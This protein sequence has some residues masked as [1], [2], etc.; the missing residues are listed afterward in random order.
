MTFDYSSIK[1]VVSYGP[2]RNYKDSLLIYSVIL[3]TSSI[4]IGAL[5]NSRNFL[6][7]CTGAGA[8]P[9][10]WTSLRR[11]DDSLFLCWSLYCNTSVPCEFA[12]FSCKCKNPKVCEVASDSHELLSW[13]LELLAA[14]LQSCSAMPRLRYLNIWFPTFAIET[15]NYLVLM[16]VKSGDGSVDFGRPSY[17]PLVVL[18]CACAMF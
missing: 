13:F 17:L 6:S 3:T 9:L 2:A 1:I 7:V 4:S 12:M 11:S 10:L 15:I 16:E 18:S 5:P 8:N 14:F